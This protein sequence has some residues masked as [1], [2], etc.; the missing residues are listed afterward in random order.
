MKATSAIFVSLLFSCCL[1]F[2]VRVS[3]KETNTLDLDEEIPTMNFVQAQTKNKVKALVYKK[4]DVISPNVTTT[5]T[6]ATTPA[7]APAP[8]P[9]AQ[10]TADSTGNGTFL[11][12]QLAVMVIILL[13]F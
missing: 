6:P 13:L 10:A 11:K 9:G 5:V 7:P 3:V 2:A 8:T 4:Q 1:I 12:T